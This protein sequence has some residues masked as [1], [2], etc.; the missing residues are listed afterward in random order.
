M[1]SQQ[2]VQTSGFLFVQYHQTYLV[3]ISFLSMRMFMTRV[4]E[5]TELSVRRRSQKRKAKLL[6]ANGKREADKTRKKERKKKNNF[7]ER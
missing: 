6:I 3:L 4:T 2:T 1:F 7:R 5:L